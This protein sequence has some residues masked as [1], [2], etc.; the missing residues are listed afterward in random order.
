MNG[1]LTKWAAAA[2]V[3]FAAAAPALGGSVTRPGD[4]IGL[5]VGSPLPQGF[6]FSNT[7]TQQ[8]ADTDPKH[9]CFLV[10]VPILIW[11]TPWTIFGARLQS[12]AGPLVPIE[13][14]S[15]VYIRGLFN[16]FV[17]AQLIWDLGNNVGFTYMLGGYFLSHSSVAFSS[18]SLN[19]R[20]GLS[21]T[22]NDWLATVNAI[23]GIQFDS[24][25]DKPQLSPCVPGS[26]LGCNPDFLNFDLTA[27]KRFGNWQVGPVGLSSLDLNAPIAAYKKQSQFALGGLVGYSLKWGSVQAFVTSDVYQKNYGGRVISGNVRFTIPLG[28]PPPPPHWPWP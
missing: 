15:G 18:G 14:N 8:C 6:Y 1:R 9:T 28:N 22:G 2:V 23:W 11:G 17:A 4:T 27:I 13:F 25:T 24:V 7:T 5:T 16:S 12:S 3:S 20:F 10:N 21:Y 19:Q 26:P